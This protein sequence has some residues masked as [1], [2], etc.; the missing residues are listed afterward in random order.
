ML[1]VAS[2]NKMLDS[3]VRDFAT[4][5][6]EFSREQ[7][8][9][10]AGLYPLPPRTELEASTGPIREISGVNIEAVIFHSRPNWPVPALQ[11]QR[12]VG[13]PVVVFLSGLWNHGKANP[14]VQSLGISLALHGYRVIA[15]EPPGKWNEEIVT[16]R[17]AC[18]DAWDPHLRT[19]APAL[20]GYV[21]DAMRALDWANVAEAAVIGHQLGAEAAMLA[22]RLDD[23]LKC[24]VISNA[25]ASLETSEFLTSSWSSLPGIAGLGDFAE[26]VGKEKP[27]LFLT[28]E[29]P[30]VKR[31]VEKILKGNKS[32]QAR[33]ETFL[34]PADFNRRMREATAGFLHERLKGLKV[35][36]YVYEEIPLTD[37]L[38]RTS[39]A[40]TVDPEELE[41]MGD[42]GVSNEI[43]G[44]ATHG[45]FVDV[46]DRALQEPYPEQAINL[47]PWLKHGRLTPI[48]EAEPILISDGP[49]SPE[50]VVLSTDGLDR[51][52]LCAIGL[53]AA[54]FYAQILHL[55]L[56]GSPTGWE[57][58]GLGG[59]PLTA[60]IASVKTLVSGGEVDATKS[61]K[62]DGPFASLVAVALK[63]YRPDLTIEITHHASNWSE[64]EAL[65]PEDGRQP[66][67]RYRPWVS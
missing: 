64:A 3:C 22:L 31:T 8:Q 24:A 15:L 47:L 6:R 49:G 33:I 38:H 61:L 17:L 10:C 58:T 13:G 42:A 23:R 57:E 56:P 32:P 51:A 48:P 63:R 45:T 25:G 18:G 2:L 29:S 36:P 34:G 44:G 7:V 54:E 39:P 4:N 60:M 40:G 21:W 20:G 37:G 52:R 41:V 28:A 26:I 35:E 19:A 43:Y 5:R 50:A 67:A 1:D 55:S 65:C 53:S 66:G 62:A 14:V 46:N 30:G 11:F 12:D 9:M 16:E 27:V 59:D